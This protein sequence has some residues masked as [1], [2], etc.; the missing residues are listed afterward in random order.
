MGLT[1]DV[2]FEEVK[3][4]TVLELLESHG[5]DLSDEKLLQLE[6]EWAAS[7]EDEDETAETEPNPR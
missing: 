5:E 1:K 3:E 6:Q 4:F 2:S 7:G